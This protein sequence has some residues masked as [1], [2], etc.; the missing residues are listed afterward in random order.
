MTAHSRLLDWLFLACLFC[1][2]FEKVHWDVAGALTLTDALTILF[3]AA[4]VLG[5][6]GRRGRPMRRTELVL[7]GFGTAFVLV[8][9]IGFFNLDTHQALTQWTKGLAKFSFHFGFLLVGFAYLTR[10]SERFY[11]RSL[12]A[13]TAGIAANAVYGVLQLA[14]A[15]AGGNLDDVLVNPLTGGASKINLYGQVNGT[16]VYRPNALTGD[17]NH[18][19]I[20]LAIPLL[21]LAPIYLRLERGHRLRRPLGVLLGLLLLVEVATLSRSG[22]LGLIVGFLVLVLPYRRKLATWT[23]LVPVAV[24]AGV[25]AV[26]TLVK[27][28]YVRT[29]FHARVST[30]NA[31]T[32]TH[33]GVYDFIPQILHQHPLFG[34]GLNNFSVYY[35]LVTGRTNW[36]PHSFYVALFVDTGLVGVAVFAVFL[37]Y[38]FRRLAAGGAVGRVLAD[39]RDPLSIRVRPLVWGMAAGLVATMASNAFYLT[40]TFFYFYAFVLLIV[41][42]PIVFGRRAVRNSLA[43]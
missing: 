24:T 39:Q 1:A 40:M 27:T 8:Y 32:S 10:R 41:A 23:A 43:A 31:S 17:P 13:F 42:V 14:V 6:L 21:V 35:E 2:T 33:L 20:V 30:G 38:F 29:V 7:L 12:A 4:Y 15:Q 28:D 22:I 16:S 34:L 9:L 11:W 5:R 3:V 36:G 18:L 26:V 37:W 19:G 25:I